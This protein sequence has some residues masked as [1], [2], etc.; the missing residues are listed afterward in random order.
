MRSRRSGLISRFVYCVMTTA[1]S[2]LLVKVSEIVLDV[3]NCDVEMLSLPES[4]PKSVVTVQQ[5][6]LK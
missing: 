5:L 1:C 3:D 4:L 6:L 2:C